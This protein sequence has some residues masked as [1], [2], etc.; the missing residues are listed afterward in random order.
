MPIGVDI[1]ERVV[2]NGYFLKLMRYQAADVPR[3]APV[4]VGRI[5]WE[6]SGTNPSEET[7]TILKW[8]L[9]VIGA[10]FFISL[11]R[12][13][14]QLHRLFNAPRALAQASRQ[15]RDRPLD[16]QRLGP[17]PGP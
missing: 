14:V 1:A 4:L 10:M 9:G 3:G 13:I 17:I 15:R 2:F 11:I 16:A 12:W 7:N 5:G 8:S 6:P